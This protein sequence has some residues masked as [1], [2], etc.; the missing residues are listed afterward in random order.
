[1]A[2]DGAV[3]EVAGRA[4]EDDSEA[5]QSRDFLSRFGVASSRLK[6]LQARTASHKRK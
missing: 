6:Q 2:M 4:E 3:P 1:M 5:G